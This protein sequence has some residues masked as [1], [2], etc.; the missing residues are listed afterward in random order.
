[1]ACTQVIF[2]SLSPTSFNHWL[3]RCLDSET[4]RNEPAA[5][6]VE[7]Y[8]GLLDQWRLFPVRAELDI[9]LNAAQASQPAHQVKP[10]PYFHR[11]FPQV[12]VSCHYCAKSV[13]STRFFELLTVLLTVLTV[14]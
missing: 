2:P 12:F 7:S 3:K 13:V 4:A 8:R 9:A 1:M 5:A 10:Q 11:Y 6:W 14:M